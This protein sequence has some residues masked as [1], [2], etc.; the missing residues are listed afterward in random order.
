MPE[1]TQLFKLTSP[2]APIMSLKVNP[3]LPIELKFCNTIMILPMDINC[4]S[5]GK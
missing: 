3:I 5:A 2:R 4:L 1:Q